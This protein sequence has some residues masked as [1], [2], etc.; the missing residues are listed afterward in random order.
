MQR[1][2]YSVAIPQTPEPHTP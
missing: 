1:N 2:D